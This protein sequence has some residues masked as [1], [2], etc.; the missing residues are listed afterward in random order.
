MR[1]Y[2][3]CVVAG[4]SCLVCAQAAVAADDPQSMPP[5]GSNTVPAS[6]APVMMMMPAAPPIGIGGGRVIKPGQLMLSYRYMLSQKN[7][8]AE[9]DD[10]VSTSKVATMRN[11]FAGRPGQPA[12][13]RSAPESMTVQVHGFGAQVGITDGL[14]ALI[15]IPYVIKERT[16]VTFRG[17]AGT[18]KLGTY[19][20][21]TSGIGDITVSGLYKLYDDAIHHLH[22]MA[23]LSFPT[24]SI[25]EDGKTLQANG[26]TGRRRLAY[27]LQLGTGTYNLLPGLT[28]WGAAGPWNW[29]VQALGQ[30][31]LGENDEGYTFG[32]RAYV[33]AWGGYT[34]GYGFTASMRLSQ[35]YTGDIDGNDNSISGASPTSDPNNYGGWKTQASFGIDYRVPEGPL[36]GVTPGIEVTVPLYQDLNGPQLEDA[37]TLFVGVRKVFTF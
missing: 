6:P 13:Y 7:Q 8:L 28:Y 18:S 27:G 23:G 26:T 17:P 31:N 29:G 35:E 9:G 11:H 33:T 1:A 36:K 37:W 20:N 24:G 30:I 32:D 3:A 2:L 16:A 25:R 19:E 22:L 10:N 12:T 14:S 34:L 15:G 4:W 21:E 5:A